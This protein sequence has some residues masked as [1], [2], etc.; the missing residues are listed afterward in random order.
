MP[1]TYT[2]A[3]V[4]N[5]GDGSPEHSTENEY[6]RAYEAAGVR[7]IP[8]R[9]CEPDQWTDLR[10]YLASKDRPDFVQWTST[11]SF[12]AKLGSRFPTEAMEVAHRHDVPFVGIH[13]DKF[14]GIGERERWIIQ[15]DPYFKC[16]LLLTADGGSNGR[17]ERAKIEHEWL[18]P[19]VAS[20]WCKKGTRREEYEGRLAFVGSWHNRY[21][22]ESRHRRDMIAWLQRT[23]PDINLW[24]KRGHH[25]IRGA[26]LTDLY[27]ST[28]VVVGDSFFP[29]NRR[30]PPPCCYSSDRIPESLGRGA[31]LVHVA[32][33]QVTDSLFAAPNL[34]TWEAWQ[35]SE[36]HRTID[37]ALA[38]PAAVRTRKRNAGIKFI[39]ENHTYDNRVVQIFEILNRR[40]MI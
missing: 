5:V 13:L 2:V 28:D 36:L 12:R 20:E 14:W 31:I 26:D 38:M 39:S 11:H 17:W 21:H 40:G 29:G 19:A 9:E 32:V 8:I 33:S 27:W 1:K 16:D 6:R 22:R 30:S 23:Y 35:W 4:G 3:L 24:P 10:L 7:V 34:L 18:P 25:G 37:E 15:G